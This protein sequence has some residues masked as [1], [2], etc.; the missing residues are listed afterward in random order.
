MGKKTY[1]E[2]KKNTVSVYVRQFNNLFN[3][4]CNRQRT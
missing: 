4:Q 1:I 3:N 2:R